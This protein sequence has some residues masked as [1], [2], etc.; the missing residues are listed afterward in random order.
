MNPEDHGREHQEPPVIRDRR[1]VN[2]DGSVR[3]PDPSAVTP[4]AAST[5]DAASPGDTTVQ[6]ERVAEL[7]ETLQRLKAEYDN[8]R[9]RTERDR[10]LVGE[11]AT[12][13]VLSQ[14]LPVLD[15]IERARA[16]GD[17][18][19]AFGA[20][21]EA[22]VTV[23]TKLGLESY[24]APGDP[25]DPQVHDAVMQAPPTADADVPV[26]AEVFRTGFRFAGRVLRPAQV[27][28]AEPADTAVPEHESAQGEGGEG[29]ATESSPEG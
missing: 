18:T 2:P 1:R 19:G 25:F 23:T 21:G 14:L 24:G 4:P 16:H 13:Q 17:L 7:T 29:A 28:V 9:K 20:V 27:A 5:A 6:D 11:A 8:Y 10:Q 12:A 3:E 22:L 26:A 15:D